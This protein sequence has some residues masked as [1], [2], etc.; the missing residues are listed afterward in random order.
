ML[1]DLG[2]LANYRTEGHEEM[3]AFVSKVNEMPEDKQEEQHEKAH[4]FFDIAKQELLKMFD[5]WMDN[6][7]FFLSS[8]GETPTGSLVTRYILSSEHITLA[9]APSLLRPREL[10][11]YESPI[12]GCKIDLKEFCTYLVDFVSQDSLDIFKPSYHCG[13][14]CTHF[15]YIAS[16]QNIW[17][18]SVPSALAPR[19]S[20]LVRYGGFLSNTQMMERGN[21]NHN[22]CSA[23][24]RKE[25]AVNARITSRSVFIDIA[26]VTSI[27]EK[28]AASSGRAQTRNVFRKVKE[29]NQA[30]KDCQGCL[31]EDEQDQR[32]KYIKTK[33]FDREETFEEKQY[34][35]KKRSIDLKA[36]SKRVPEKKTGYYKTPYADKKVQYGKCFSNCLQA[37]QDELTAR[38]IPFLEGDGINN[39]KRILQTK[40]RDDW[41]A[42]NPGVDEKVYDENDDLTK[43]FY[44]VTDRS[45]FPTETVRR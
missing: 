33:M 7:L 10:V 26:S 23:N 43:H 16:G 8:F 44:P 42:Q 12:H 39:L 11:V 27:S 3:E 20:I 19:T 28:R 18:R 38:G 25:R 14:N 30:E 40:L 37:F 22:I 4:N 41:K 29:F 13:I 9:N 36:E 34:Q 1:K 5:R 24:S 6:R 35:E 21:K 31:S 45:N 15:E 32:Y 17:D 2:R